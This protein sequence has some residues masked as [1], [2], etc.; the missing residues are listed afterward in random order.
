MQ[1][2]KNGRT[3]CLA[4]GLLLS[5][6]GCRQSKPPSIEVCITD[7][8]GGADCIEKDGSKLYRAPSQMENY[9]ATNQSDQA[10]LISW[11]YEIQ[12]DHVEMAMSEIKRQAKDRDSL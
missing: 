3:Y 4:L 10:A 11:C 5:L 6:T 12:R 8:V 1:Q 9:W 2:L 7:G